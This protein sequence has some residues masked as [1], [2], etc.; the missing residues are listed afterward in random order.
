MG[1]LNS[2]KLL[3]RKDREFPW[4]GQRGKDSFFKRWERKHS[5]EQETES[6]RDGERQGSV[7]LQSRKS[8]PLLSRR[9]TGGEQQRPWEKTAVCSRE[10]DRT[11]GNPAEDSWGPKWTFGLVSPKIKMLRSY[12][13]TMLEKAKDAAR[14][15]PLPILCELAGTMADTK[16]S[17]TL[18]PPG[19]DTVSAPTNPLLTLG[20]SLEEI[21]ARKG[22]VWHP[23]LSWL[24][25]YI[26]PLRQ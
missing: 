18:L 25:C 3:A 16:E 26:L 6:E 23:T 20:L 17:S 9:T 4:E 10:A 14:G 7:G 22:N 13:Q 8:S 19:W 15:S 2:D 24:A 1:T 21:K 12:Q 5:R 11:T